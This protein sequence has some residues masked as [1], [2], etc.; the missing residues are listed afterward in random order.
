MTVAQWVSD[1]LS[2]RSAEIKPRT[3][4]SYQDLITRYIVPAIGETDVEQLRPE[5]IRHL[6]ATI[7]DAGHGR[8]AEYCYV[9]LKAAFADCDTDPMRKVKRPKHRQ[10][11]PVP[12]ND[13]Q[14][15]V[16]LAACR[17]H[18]HGLA[19]S[20]ALTCGLRR[21]E[22]CG[23]R[24]QDIDLATGDLHVCNQR[25]RLAS[26]EIIDAPPKSETSDRHIPIPDALLPWLKSARGL[27]AA[28]LCPLTPS[29]LDAAHRALVK[30]LDLPPIPLHGLRHSM[31][32]ASLRHGGNMRALQAIAGHES[33]ATTAKVYAHP[34]RDLLKA[35][36][37]AAIKA[38]YNVLQS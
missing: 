2:L 19:L 25:M 13:A 29:G 31:I 38:C 5:D 8:T 4:E 21:G 27:P 30:S 17:T 9:V 6:L 14:M 3:R 1:W 24:W 20:L 36:L 23:L 22:I 11:H 12:W 18:R 33:Y 32:S 35:S 15:T 16:Y 26:G 10:H 37:D 34:D 28:Y 7:L